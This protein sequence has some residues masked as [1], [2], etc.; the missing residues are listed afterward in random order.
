MTD[1]GCHGGDHYVAYQWIHENYITDETCSIY[2]ARGHDNGAPCDAQLKCN[3]CAPGAT[4][5][6]AQHN[7]KIY[8]VET[9]NNVTLEEPMMQEIL[10]RGPIACGIDAM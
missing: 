10:A 2:R 8:G 7:Y 4:G 5:C 9:F 3:N 6:W 1:Q